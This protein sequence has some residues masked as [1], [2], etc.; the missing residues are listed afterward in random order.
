MEKQGLSYSGILALA[1]E[2]K[3]KR[4]DNRRAACEAK[5]AN[6]KKKIRS[7]SFVAMTT[8]E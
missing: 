3:F 8:Q 7:L 5:E 2:N 6:L 1:E 4:V